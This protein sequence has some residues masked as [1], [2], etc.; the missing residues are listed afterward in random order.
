[1]AG[2]GVLG[3]KQI[4]AEAERLAEEEKGE[5]GG[6]KEEEA[7]EGDDDLNLSPELMKLFEEGEKEGEK[8]EEEE[9]GEEEE[10]EEEGVLDID[11]LDT[12]AVAR[13]L[14]SANDRNEMMADQIH[15][16]TEKLDELATRTGETEASAL[17]EV[18]DG[19]FVTA[20]TMKSLLKKEK[21]KQDTMSIDL[22]RL[23]TKLQEAQLKA[24]G[25]VP[26][27]DKLAEKHWP[28]FQRDATTLSMI[29][30]SSNP[31][32]TFYKLAVEEEA[33]QKREGKSAKSSQ[34]KVLKAMR[35]GQEAARG[36]GKSGGTGKAKPTS[37][38]KEVDKRLL[39]L[40]KTNPAE[41]LKIDDSVIL[42][43]ED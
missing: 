25:K 15:A 6:E 16:L 37:K 34:A 22:A 30:R 36:A 1:M 39:E 10:E 14:K 41:L 43:M 17:D 27:Y 2:S 26:H 35:K 13:L 29:N 4:L 18:D 21:E 9:E 42:S 38:R 31:P 24:S 32:L 5:E 20:G 3:T 40:A 8:K 11:D 19:D 28:T 33:K 12:P 7:S 23:T